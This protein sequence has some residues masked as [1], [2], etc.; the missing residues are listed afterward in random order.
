MRQ[1]DFAGREMRTAADNGDLGR[2]MVD[3]AERS[4]GDQGRFFGQF[5]DERIDL[6]DFQDL[7]ESQR[8]QD[9]RQRFAQQGLSAS[10]PADHEDVMQSR[11]RDG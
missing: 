2:G 4:L 1:A 3:L 7:F 8:R 6:R 5:A 11:S 10:R 9:A